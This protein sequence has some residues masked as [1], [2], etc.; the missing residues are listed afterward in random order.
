MNTNYAQ[1]TDDEIIL[2]EEMHQ[3]ETTPPQPEVVTGEI[4]QL[5]ATQPRAK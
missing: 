5:P 1:V 3:Q 4:I 2:N